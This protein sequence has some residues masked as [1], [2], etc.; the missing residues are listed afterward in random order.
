MDSFSEVFRRDARLSV[1]L[2]RKGWGKTPWTAFEESAIKSR[3]L[4][5]RFTSMMVVKLDNAELPTWIPTHELYASDAADTR[6]E[7]AAVIRARAREK[8]AVLKTLSASELALQRSREESLQIAR[9]RRAQSHTAQSEIR[10]ELALLYDEIQRIVSEIKLGDPDYDIVAGAHNDTCV[11][12]SSRQS[13]SLIL[14]P[15]GNTLRDLVLRENRWQGRHPLPSPNNPQPGGTH[16]LG[17]THYVPTLSQEDEW[18]WKW[19]P[20]LDDG[21]LIFLNAEEK[22]YRSSDLAEAI[23]KNHIERLFG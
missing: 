1:V 17:A 15:I 22:E 10:T 2:F 18:A 8:G 7:M 19:A 16:H 14:Y 4:E 9:E 6:A 12:S 11:I 23:L 5:T 13:T 20:N 21:N 3:A